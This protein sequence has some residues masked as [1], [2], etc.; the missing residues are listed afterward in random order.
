MGLRTR[1]IAC[2]VVLTG[3]VLTAVPGGR[4]FAADLAARISHLHSPG[5]G[6]PIPFILD[7]RKH[8]PRKHEPAHRGTAAGRPVS[9]QHPAAAAPAAPAPK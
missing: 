7:L 6:G 1:V 4:S 8:A 2:S 5:T 9:P 3:V